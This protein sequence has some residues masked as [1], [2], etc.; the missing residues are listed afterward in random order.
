[1]CDAAPVAL[2][3]AAGAVDTLLAPEQPANNA[4]VATVHSD[5]AKERI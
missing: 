2:V 1:M 4:A 5:S 3:A